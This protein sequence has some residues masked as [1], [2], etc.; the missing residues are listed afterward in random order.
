MYHDMKITFKTFIT[1]VDDRDRIIFFIIFA[2][3]LP[4]YLFVYLVELNVKSLFLNLEL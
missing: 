1:R 2:A 4:N 3:K